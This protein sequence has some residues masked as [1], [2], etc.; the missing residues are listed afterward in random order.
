MP[1]A[2]SR[3]FRGSSQSDGGQ[4]RPQGGSSGGVTGPDQ[5]RVGASPDVVPGASLQSG[6]GELV[7]ICLHHRTLIVVVQP[8]RH[9]QPLSFLE[10]LAVVVEV[11][12]GLKGVLVVV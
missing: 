1:V 7:V 8:V 3:V 11:S 10:V 5:S 4:S 9:A 6:G 2:A 12:L